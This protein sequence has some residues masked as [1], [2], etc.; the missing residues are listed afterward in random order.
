M[1]DVR[2]IRRTSP[3]ERY[4]AQIRDEIK[5]VALRQLAQ[6]GPSGVSVN[7]IGKEL[8]VTGPAFYR[9]FAS[10]DELLTELVVDA[11]TDM[12]VAL[13]SA[14]D[15]ASGTPARSSLEALARAYREWAVT[16]PH[17]YRL[18]YAPLLPGYDPNTEQL[19]EASQASMQLL[20]DAL[21]PADGA[22]QPPKHLATQA[23]AWTKARV[24][25]SDASTA[26]RAV[27]IWSR[28]HG[29]VSLEIAGAFASMGLDADTLFDLELTS[30]GR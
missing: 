7:A 23:T 24:L 25:N 17:R 18:L 16:H 11:Y 22:K 1:S 27:Q 30:L 26:V 15:K 4:R 19:V 5:Q 9:Y 14:A 3:R 12:A 10:R 20:L 28:L 8:G 29:F 6:L 13:R 21:P 2:A